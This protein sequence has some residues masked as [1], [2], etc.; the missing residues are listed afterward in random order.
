[1]ASLL[2]TINGMRERHDTSQQAF[3]QK[4]RTTSLLVLDDLG[5]EY[6]HTWVL[7]WLNR[8]RIL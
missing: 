8:V 5:A 1:M 4:L 2:D 6:D 7:K 3:E